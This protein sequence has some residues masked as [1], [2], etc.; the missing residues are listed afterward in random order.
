MGPPLAPALTGAL[1]PFGGRRAVGPVILFLVDGL[2]WA[3]LQGWAQRSASPASRTWKAS[4]RPIT[5]VFPSTTTAALTSIATGV[6]PARHGL[7]GYR[8]YL[9]RWGVVADMLRMS[10]VGVNVPD[11]L[12]GPNW[13]PE[14]LTG[15]VNLA[16]RGVRVTALSRDRF[17]GTGFSRLL[18]SG[19][20]FVGYA[21]ATDLAH[22]LT[23]LLSRPSPPDL[24]S[25]YWDELDTIQHLHGPRPELIDLELERVAMLLEFVAS[26]ADPRTGREATVLITGDHGQVPATPSAR[27]RLEQ[28]EAIA[29]E[30]ARPPTGDRR[31]GL[32]AARPGRADALAAELARFL[33][34]GSQVIPA[35]QALASGLFGDEPYHAELRER[36]GDLVVLVHSPAC[37]TY[38]PPGA[39]EPA[40]HLFG[41]HGGLE[42]EEL[43]VPLV[44]GELRA[45]RPPGIAASSGEIT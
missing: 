35:E 15:T 42:A 29:R 19:A 40:R 2:G 17:Q 3:Q 22:E 7:V 20:E 8:Q 36:I 25:V 18:Y 14:L 38:L 41:A 30:L 1:D 31:A 10:P 13:S 44:S 11:A 24:I 28:S 34:D 43:I 23:G 12:I 39:A 6:P 16:G 9:P 37:L 32:L 27:L 33:P 45:F 26:H 21:T 4:G 5:T